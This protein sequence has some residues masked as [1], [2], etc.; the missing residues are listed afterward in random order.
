MLSLSFSAAMLGIEGY[1]VRVEADSAAG[2]PAFAIIGL[3]DRALGE[4]RERVRAAILNSGFAYPAGRLLVN[5]SPADVRKA[6]PAFDLAIALALMGIDEQIDRPTLREFI[7]L[8][9]LALDGKLQPVSGILPMVLGAR[10]A[11]FTKLIV[12][13]C[14]AEE[15]ALVAGIE[16][17]AVDCLQAAVTVL[18]GNGSK[19]RQRTAA[20]TLELA[21]EVVHGDLA[22]VR[23]QLAAKR[24]LEIAAA[25]GHNLL[26]VGP[27]GCGKTMLARRLP[28]I[29][30]AMS[31]HEALEVTKIYSVAGLLLGRAG[32]VRA[33]PFRFPH[34]TISQ[35]ALVGGGALVKPGEIS[36]AHH[37]VLFLDE[38]PE[39]TRGAI[40]VMRQPL[41]E[42]T[43]TIA[44]VAGTFTYPA[45]FQ[46][47]ASMNPCPC[48]YR[49]T[50]NMECR[51]DEA[52]VAKYVS[53]LSGPLLDRIDLQIEIARVA[54]DDMVRY[55]CG[56]RST[57]IRERVVA[58][59]DRQSRR[60]A[61]A[62]MLCN[63]E[64]PGNAMRRYCPLDET[65]LRLLA[66][67]SAKRQFS[68][69]A[70]DRIARVARTIADLAG[71]QA[72]CAAHVAEAIQYR[73]LERLGAAA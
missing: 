69:R 20:P 36:L 26:L 13:A 40:E 51:C 43:V 55:E 12:P 14:N 53:K 30:P 34:H 57:T 52:I 39:F 25:G 44:R 18:G 67:A 42:G 35:T 56:E 17:Y 23:G 19:W 64:I 37:G 68:A 47:V 10:N 54:F 41:E 32:I 71:E 46:L 7:T 8:G 61:G 4:A 63:A 2:T 11:G 29:L 59:R 24:A 21:D 22:D 50:R 62:A 72:I 48:G 1:V 27:P 16:L 60:F 66:Q 73:S 33:R 45:R 9:E 38:L 58:A 65:A 49:G 5:L 15:A 70:L 28:S 6:G 3:P 31:L